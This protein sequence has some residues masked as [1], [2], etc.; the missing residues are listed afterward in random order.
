MKKITTYIIIGMITSISMIP[1]VNGKTHQDEY[2][3]K[4]TF[5]QYSG[6]FSRNPD[7]QIN[8]EVIKSL[9]KCNSENSLIN[10][11]DAEKQEKKSH[12]LEDSSTKEWTWMFYDDADFDNAFDPLTMGTEEYPTFVQETCSGENLNI[13]VLQDG[14]HQPASLWYINGQHETELIREMDEV[15][16]GEYQTIYDF[17]QFSKENFPAERYFLSLYNHG[18]GWRGACVD[19]TDND[20][21]SMDE[22][23]N[24][25]TNS[26]GIDIICF[27]A[28]CLMGSLESVYELRDC[29][30]MYIGSEAVSGYGHWYGT[31]EAMCD[32]FE[33]NH[34]M[35]NYEI[36][37]Y[38]IETIYSNTPA[39]D[40]I[41]MS[42]IR[43]DYLDSLALN[44]DILC[45]HL[46]NNYDVSRKNI[47]SILSS[48]STFDEG[49][50]DFFEFINNYQKV[51]NNQTIMHC[52]ENVITTYSEVIIAECHGSNFPNANGLS[53]YFPIN[54][55]SY[56]NNYNDEQY[57]LD[58]SN[59]TNWDEFIVRIMKTRS[60]NPINLIIKHIFEN[61]LVKIFP[62][63][64]FAQYQNS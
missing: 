32:L 18:A 2:I 8:N 11:Y 29:V 40:M 26:G 54:K 43:T 42:A 14:E 61:I 53:I 50:V 3:I 16:M 1:F 10:H 60:K 45:Q 44:I 64:T 27:T 41:T 31:I 34:S 51:E 25:L 4:N 20:M 35:T 19:D 46:L 33:K 56:N 5:N 28:P 37:E 49:V 22:I 13:V 6:L 39:P 9:I 17:I 59:D 24:A 55:K 7:D 47:L 48:I 38:V 52:I 23:Q 21:L 63:N 30:D 36:G 57:G 15:N 58:I 62:Y 12:N